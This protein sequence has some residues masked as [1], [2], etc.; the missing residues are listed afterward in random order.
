VNPLPL[1]TSVTADVEDDV[2][3]CSESCNCTWLVKPVIITPSKNFDMHGS[4]KLSVALRICSQ[5]ERIR[6]KLSLPDC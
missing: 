4:V 2:L 1:G 6:N 3:F 5:K